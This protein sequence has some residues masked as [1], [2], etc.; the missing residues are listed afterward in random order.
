MPLRPGQ[1]G[2]ACSWQLLCESS[3]GAD[4]AQRPAVVGE[5]R[6]HG[7]GQGEVLGGEL[8]VPGLA[9]GQ[10]Q[11][12]LGIVVGRVDGGEPAEAVH[13]GL[14]AAGVVLSAGQCLQHAARAGLDGDGAL[15]QGGR[16]VGVAVAEQLQPTLVPL[17]D[18][19]LGLSLIAHR[20]SS[21]S[22]A[23]NRPGARAARTWRMPPP[24]PRRRAPTIDSV[25]STSADAPPPDAT[26]LDVRPF[27]ALTY[28]DHDPEHL[29]RVS[30][31]AYDLVTAAGRDRLAAA[32][33]HN[34]VRL[35]LPHV[36]P[37]PGQDTSRPARDRRSADAAA[38]TLHRWLADGV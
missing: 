4:A 38:R 2:W 24:A 26:G 28:R 36:D 9:G 17:V 37:V 8:Q 7:H 30:S 15:E 20:R 5:V 27:R 34:I 6:A 21:P 22:R 32:D 1:W 23:R 12:E 19:T 3:S 18:P 13:R 10:P 35:I 16:R 33:P 29:A 25:P 11:S 14:V 31:P